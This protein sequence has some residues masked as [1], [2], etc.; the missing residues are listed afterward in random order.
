M[1][2]INYN[3]QNDENYNTNKV[4]TEITAIKIPNNARVIDFEFYNDKLLI[5]LIKY[6]N[7]GIVFKNIK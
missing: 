7:E 6:K 4:I 3:K 1:D 2:N 5:C